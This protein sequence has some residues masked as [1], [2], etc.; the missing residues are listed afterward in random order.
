[1][2]NEVFGRIIDGG[3]VEDAV[4]ATLQLWLPTYIA[5]VAAQNGLDRSAIPNIRSYHTVNSYDKWPEDQLPSL[6]VISGGVPD[7]ITVASG[8]VHRA[9][10]AFGFAVFCSA[11]T[12]SNTARMAKRYAAAIR[13]CFV[14]HQSLGGFARGVEWKGEVYDDVESVDSRS[15]ASARGVYLVEVDDVVSS[16]KGPS[17]PEPK[18]NPAEA[19]EPVIAES[20]EVEIERVL[21]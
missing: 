15:L 10:F 2:A 8:G 7:D 13:A 17:E 18:P 5:E 21:E 9:Q 12:E 11:N 19:Y 20:V 16:G 1:M 3:Q 4:I 6:V 14:Q